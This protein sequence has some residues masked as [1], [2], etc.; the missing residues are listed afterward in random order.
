MQMIYLVSFIILFIKPLFFTCSN[1]L[2]SSTLC[3]SSFKN[4]ITDKIIS[5]IK[6]SKFV[7]VDLT[8]NNH[9]AYVD[10]AN[11][12]LQIYVKQDGQDIQFSDESAIINGLK[13]NGFQFTPNRKEHLQKV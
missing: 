10:N 2:K 11:D 13:M 1:Y 5:D 8:Y 12:Y 6:T 7:I 3:I 4:D 9:G